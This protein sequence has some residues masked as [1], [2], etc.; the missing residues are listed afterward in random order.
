MKE[1]RQ[2]SKITG[3]FTNITTEMVTE[4]ENEPPP[5]PEGGAESGLGGGTKLPSGGSKGKEENGP[6][7]GP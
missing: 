4:A 1:L 5:M 7:E 6:N 2:S 3:I